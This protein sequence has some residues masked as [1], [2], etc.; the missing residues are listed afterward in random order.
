MNNMEFILHEINVSALLQPFKPKPRYTET[1][2]YN[3]VTNLHVVGF[4]TSNCSHLQQ[5]Q[6]SSTRLDYKTQQVCILLEIPFMYNL[7]SLFHQLEVQG[8]E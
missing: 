8:E 1:R 2:E 6:H 3:Q 5:H 7:F 4:Q